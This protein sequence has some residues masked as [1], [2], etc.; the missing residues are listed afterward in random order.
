MDDAA[1]VAQ[2]I[3]VLLTGLARRADSVGLSDLAKRLREVAKE[4]GALARKSER[5]P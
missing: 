2:Q 3:Q 4:S 1:D 5:T